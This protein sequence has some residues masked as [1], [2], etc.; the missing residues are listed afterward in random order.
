MSRAVLHRLYPQNTCH[1][2]WHCPACSLYT[3]A[4]SMCLEQ[5]VLKMV[6][7]IV[8]TH[9][10]NQQAVF[11]LMAG[12]LHLSASEDGSTMSVTAD[13]S[14]SVLNSRDNEAVF[15]DDAQ[16]ADKKMWNCADG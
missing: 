8:C 6:K 3:D 16:L 9:Y 7:C 12:R 2:G 4:A 11:E 15:Y 13:T 10:H 14:H 1:V 5:A